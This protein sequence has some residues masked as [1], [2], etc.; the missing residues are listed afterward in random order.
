[1]VTHAAIVALAAQHPAPSRPNPHKPRAS[2]LMAL[3]VTRVPVGAQPPQAE[4]VRTP[5]A[6]GAPPARSERSSSAP[7]PLET[8]PAAAAPAKRKSPTTNPSGKRQ[9]PL[10]DPAAREEEPQGGDWLS[11]DQQLPDTPPAQKT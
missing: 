5:Q 9:A 1:F 8:R 10:S 11:M 3:D 4:S 6:E 7:E 2:G